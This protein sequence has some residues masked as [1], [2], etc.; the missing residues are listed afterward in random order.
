MFRRKKKVQ[1]GGR[2]EDPEAMQEMQP[3][4]STERPTE[5]D[6]EDPDKKKRNDKKKRLFDILTNFREKWIFSDAK[7]EHRKTK[8]AEF[9]RILAGADDLDIIRSDKGTTLLQEAVSIHGA[10]CFTK[11]LL[12]HGASPNPSCYEKSSKTTKCAPILLAVYKAEN[13]WLAWEPY[14]LRET[15]CL[16]L[17]YGADFTVTDKNQNTILHLLMKKGCLDVGKEAMTF[18]LGIS[19][20]CEETYCTGKRS[21]PIVLRS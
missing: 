5:E 9:R 11:A 4:E 7:E 12:E 15:L 8:E 13:G 3:L 10:L 14:E 2:D 18:V 21:S 20:G 16:L 1:R 6:E 17:Q 19:L